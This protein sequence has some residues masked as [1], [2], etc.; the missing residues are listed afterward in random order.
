MTVEQQ[1]TTTTEA[2]EAQ[3]QQ[4]EELSPDALRKQLE[5]VRKESANYRTRVRELEPLAA[6]AKQLKESGQ[7][8]L[9]KLTARAEK[10]ERERETATA[11][12]L[13]LSVAFEK[14]LNPKQAKRLTGTSREELEADADEILVD[15]PAIKPDGRPKGDLDQGVR[16]K[17]APTNPKQADLA[18][19]EADLQA[20]HRR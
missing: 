7:S 6:E 2:P 1:N 20:A 17:A 5:K 8:D 14:G 9:E 19:I 10:A 16:Q 3:E 4:T 11:E 12:S 15:F 13:R 18:Q